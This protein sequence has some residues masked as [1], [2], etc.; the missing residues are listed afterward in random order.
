MKKKRAKRKDILKRE[1]TNIYTVYICHIHHS[2]HL[3]TADLQTNF[4]PNFQRKVSFW[5][6]NVF[7]Y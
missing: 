2:G 4:V 7:G 6:K 5:K 3:P 1:Y